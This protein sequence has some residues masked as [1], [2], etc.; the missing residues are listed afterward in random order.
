MS[1]DRSVEVGIGWRGTGGRSVSRQSSKQDL[2]NASSGIFRFLPPESLNQE[3]PPKLI[4]K[5]TPAGGSRVSLY[6]DDDDAGDGGA[7]KKL[8]SGCQAGDITRRES[9]IEEL[10]KKLETIK[11]LIGK[12]EE[13]AEDLLKRQTESEE[14][15]SQ[16]KKDLE[17][18]DLQKGVY[19]VLDSL[20][21]DRREYS[22]LLKKATEMQ[23]RHAKGVFL[24]GENEE[25]RSLMMGANDLEKKLLRSLEELDRLKI[26][27]EALIDRQKAILEARRKKMEEEAMKN[28]ALML[29][30]K[31]ASKIDKLMKSLSHVKAQHLKAEHIHRKIQESGTNIDEDEMDTD[32]IVLQRIGVDTQ[33]NTE[34]L[35]R[36]R[37]DINKLQDAA[38]NA[39]N[40]DDD[41]NVDIV[42][43]SDE[44]RT[45]IEAS[46]ENI[47]QLEEDIEEFLK[48]QAERFADFM[49]KLKEEEENERRRRQLEEEE[50]ERKRKLEEDRNRELSL[51]DLE[52]EENRVKQ[53]QNI[54][55][56]L[57]GDMIELHKMKDKVL[58]L[59][60]K[61]KKIKNVRRKRRELYTITEEDE[62]DEDLNQLMDSTN[63]LFGDLADEENKVLRIKA[64]LD[65]EDIMTDV[66]K[67]EDDILSH[68]KKIQKLSH[69]T[70]ALLDNEQQRLSEAE[71]KKLGQDELLLNFH[72]D[73][74]VCKKKLDQI[75]V[76]LDDLFNKQNHTEDLIK[77]VDNPT[78]TDSFAMLKKKTRKL[79]EKNQNTEAKL[80]SLK[81]K[82]E[83]DI[84]YC[85]WNIKE[86]HEEIA[87][88]EVEL[89]A[90]HSTTDDIKKC[91]EEKL[92]EQLRLKSEEDEQRLKND[93]EKIS[94]LQ[95]N[96]KDIGAKQRDL[97]AQLR[98]DLDDEEENRRR[99][100]DLEKLLKQKNDLENV[101]KSLEDISDKFQEWK[102]FE[103]TE[104]EEL[105]LNKY[106]LISS[107]S[108]PSFPAGLIKDPKLLEVIM[109]RH[110]EMLELRKR[111][112]EEEQ[113][114]KEITEALEEMEQ[115]Q[116]EAEL[117]R[118]AAQSKE[119]IK[120]LIP[121]GS[122][123]FG[124]EPT[125]RSDFHIDPEEARAAAASRKA[126]RM[127][128][129]ESSVTPL[130][131]LGTALF[132]L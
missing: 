7:K 95:D 130:E 25:L 63:N 115:R 81:P 54:L 69:E 107:L 101:G 34:D 93:R 62:N 24:D 74:D 11:T 14:F 75:K 92:S 47:Q 3:E 90:L 132:T 4:L 82:I 123:M 126:S 35:L 79:Q 76:S 109:K 50:N 49:K 105:E 124:S 45:R 88:Q 68:S 42:G 29:L 52:A 71:T 57:D 28:S 44:I 65:A 30:L 19:R 2:D 131:S 40:S 56:M 121:D 64:D 98:T 21:G 86:I 78:I 55:N 59:V 117:R 106:G 84:D 118:L 5:R 31:D 61:Q 18:Y 94:S 8:S 43:Q 102:D 36:I 13:T 51:L 20:D 32:E 97:E 77:Q 46:R 111:L 73:L 116:R 103:F 33:T 53:R 127:Q 104:E 80:M 27:T 120:D 23:K 125:F 22:R 108:M 60:E 72:S 41:E 17:G 39:I 99:L 9:E 26:K 58:G 83:T 37:E 129:R 85:V 91:C 1:E 87:E 96:V 12:V 100:E 110:K 48:N 119:W 16:M 70:D 15:Q 112:A 114:M 6:G 38:M 128:S 10:I 113:R 66:N 67:V 122:A 89:S